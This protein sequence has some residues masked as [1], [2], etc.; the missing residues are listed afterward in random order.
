MSADANGLTPLA[1]SFGR[2]HDYLRISL[3]DH[4]NLRCTYC[5]PEDAK[6]YSS[7]Q[8]MNPAEIEA[9]ASVFVNQFGV[10]KIRLTGGEPLV[11]KE[12]SEILKRIS[13]LPVNL[14]ITT[15]AILLD[16]Y[17]DELKAAG[18]RSLNLSLDTLQP[19]RFHTITRRNEFDKVWQN[20]QQALE[21]GFKVK[22]NMVVMKGENEDEVIEFAKMSAHPNVHIRF[23]EFMPFE[24]NSWHWEKVIPSEEI[25][26]RIQHAFEIEKLTD[27]PNST[28]KAWQIKGYAGT[29]AVISTITQHFCGSCNRIRLTADGKLRNCLFATEEFDLLNALRNGK[30]IAAIIRQGIDAKKEKLG[31]LPQFQNETEVLEQL[32]LRSMV[33]IGG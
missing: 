2:V 17:W 18:I 25:L 9:I 14:G 6:F 19:V 8:L 12:F 29:F 10:K 23:I 11:R 32:S 21:L 20:F 15:N 13:S 3:T 4:C 31:G 1:D 7:P 5:M 24:G 28:S 22:L 30:D 16:R 26:N 33:K 27:K